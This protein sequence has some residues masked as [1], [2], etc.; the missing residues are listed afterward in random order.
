[1]NEL[2][3]LSSRHSQ[4]HF[5]SPSNK[6]VV[7]SG[8]V[9]I[10]CRAFDLSPIQQQPPVS[11][12]NEIVFPIDPGHPRR[13]LRRQKV[14]L[15]A[16]TGPYRLPGRVGLPDNHG[17][18]HH[19]V[20]VRTIRNSRN[21]TERNGTCPGRSVQLVEMCIWS[22]VGIRASF[23]S[24]S[25]SSHHVELVCQTHSSVCMWCPLA[26]SFSSTPRT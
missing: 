1:M 4:P 8:L 3:T 15:V 6:V 26:S 14:G 20:P 7:S 22:I 17:Q 19:R 2:L 18:P 25:S 11:H 13:L 21:G 9:V 24:S 16:G 5:Y 23:S 12:V 10:R